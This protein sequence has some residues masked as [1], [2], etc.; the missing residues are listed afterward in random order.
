VGKSIL[1]MFQWHQCPGG[2]ST[3]NSQWIFE[4]Y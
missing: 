3:T 4:E 1:K 2:G